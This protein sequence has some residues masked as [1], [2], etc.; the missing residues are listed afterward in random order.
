MHDSM[1]VKLT[2]LKNYYE[3]EMVPRKIYVQAFDFRY[4]KV[5]CT[6]FFDMSRREIN[7]LDLYFVKRN[8][9][10]TLSVPMGDDFCVKA[11][12]PEK[13]FE[14]K[15]FFNIKNERDSERKF[16]LIDFFKYMD[17]HLHPAQGPQMDRQQKAKAYRVEEPDAIFYKTMILWDIVHIERHTNKGNVTARNRAKVQKL[18]P[19]LYARIRDKNISVRFTAN[20]IDEDKEQNLIDKELSKHNL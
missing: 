20:H 5:N 15:E 6:I 8:T 17:A 7:A 2:W 14:I 10:D 4:N 3:H 18:L 16:N 11:R 13:Y 9:Q 19:D 1:P 12:D